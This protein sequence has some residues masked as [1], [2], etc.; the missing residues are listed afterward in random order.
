MEKKQ[1]ELCLEILRRFNKTGLLKD[2]ILIGSWCIVFYKDYFSN[3][4]YINQAII[5]TRDIDFLINLPSKIKAGVNIPDL[6]R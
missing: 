3:Q 6:P 4:P 1:Y 5:K 2:F